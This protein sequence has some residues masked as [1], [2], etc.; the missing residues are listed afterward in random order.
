MTSK[1]TIRIKREKGIILIYVRRVWVYVVEVK[2][3]SFF[4]NG[5][6][7]DIGV[8]VVYFESIGITFVLKL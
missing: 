3:S 6:P 5:T 4:R 7:Y 1:E 2:R 8:G